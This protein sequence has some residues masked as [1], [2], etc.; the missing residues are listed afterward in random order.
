MNAF[1]GN[2]FTGRV[3]ASRIAG[4][5]TV[6]VASLTMM[7]ITG[8]SQKDP[9]RN[10]K[11]VR[12]FVAAFNAHNV[13]QMLELAEEDVQLFNLNEA[14]ITTDANGRK[15]LG[16]SMQRYF[17]SCPSCRSSL[18]WIKATGERIVAYERA[19]WKDKK[20]SLRTLKG[21]S[22]YEFNN[23][24]ISRVYYFQDEIVTPAKAIAK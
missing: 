19:T 7:A 9:I 18:E 1:C 2:Y 10:E 11:Q 20:G 23:S 16:E 24:K 5:L 14:K 21:L 12:D 8:L 17:K 3:T 22:V 6:V 15:A 4:V 13:G